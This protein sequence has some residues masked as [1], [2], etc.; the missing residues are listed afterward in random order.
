M[1]REFARQFYNSKDWKDCRKRYI[2]LMPRY[3]RGLCE[4]CYSKG[5][6]TLGE[7]LHHKIELN[8]NNIHDRNITLNHDNL[9]LLCYEC[10]KKRH[11][12]KFERTYMFD[13]NG[14]ILPG[15]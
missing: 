4:E 8:P 5:I 2:Q 6:H 1:A 9:I 11:R 15:K 14:N 13:D 7:E 10:H 12:A 3:M